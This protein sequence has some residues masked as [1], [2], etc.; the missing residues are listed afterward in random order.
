MAAENYGKH[1][2]PT[3]RNVDKRPG[4]AFPK[5]YM[6]NGVFKSLEEVVHFYNTRDVEDWPPPEVTENVNTDEL[7]DLGLTLEE[8]HLI[9]A[10]MRT[11]SDGYQADGESVE[12]MARETVSSDLGTLN[13]IGGS[14]AISYLVRTAGR[15]QVHL[16]NV[17]GQ[18][19]ATLADAWQDA[20]EQSVSISGLGLSS[21][22]YFVHLV[23]LDQ[24]QTKKIVVLK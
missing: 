17:N 2:V 5:A 22:V 19:V 12:E 11:L 6:H 15:V 14:S 10:F 1:K 16:F 8:E 18:K 23:S 9:V 3:L 4:R 21:G 20:G 13:P 7:G 24:V